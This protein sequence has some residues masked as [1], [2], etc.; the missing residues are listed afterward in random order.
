MKKIILLTVIIFL[1][2]SVSGQEI[3]KVPELTVGEKHSNMV[4]MFWA[5]LAPGIKFAKDHSISPYEYGTYYG[6]LFAVNRNTETGFV[7]YAWSVLHNWQLFVR[8]SDKEI[9]IETESDSLFIFKVPSNIML[10]VFGEEGFV[11][12]TA[13]EMLEMMNGSHAQISGSYG[14]ISKMV[15][16]G[17]WVVVTVSSKI[18]EKAD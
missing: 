5:N 14:C 3:F 15:L 2:I 10:D 4:F 6:K 8:E 12:V 1:S 9:E 11:G 16:D 18:L 13:Q 17:E 7:G